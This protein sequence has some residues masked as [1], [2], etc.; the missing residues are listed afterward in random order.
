MNSN[1]L[2]EPKQTGSAE[3]SL[4]ELIGRVSDDLKL[5][6]RQELQL[7]SHELGESLKQAKREGVG[8]ALGGAALGAGALLLLVAV[9]L[10]LALVMPVWGAA[11]LVGGFMTAAGSALLLRAK[12]K[13]SDVTFLPERTMRNV[14]QDIA[15]IKRAAT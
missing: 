5:L 12:A 13:L 3:P 2:S 1:P 7:A 6:T 10:L 11:L 14:E 4:A 9:V 15:A 8:L